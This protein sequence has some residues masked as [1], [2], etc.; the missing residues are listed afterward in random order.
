MIRSTDTLLHRHFG[1]GLADKGVEILDPATGTGS[2]VSDIIEF[3][4][5]EVLTRKYKKEL[6]A[7][8]IA[9]LPYT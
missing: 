5:R 4:P 7:N 3:L 2:Y 9:I 1:R 8:E 6:H